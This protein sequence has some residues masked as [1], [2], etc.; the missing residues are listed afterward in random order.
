MCYRDSTW[1]FFK[2]R[3]ACSP[4]TNPKWCISQRYCVLVLLNILYLSGRTCK[5]NSCTL[6]LGANTSCK[7]V[8]IVELQRQGIIFQL[9]SSSADDWCLNSSFSFSSSM[10]WRRWMIFL[11]CL[12]KI[13]CQIKVWQKYTNKIYNYIWCKLLSVISLRSSSTSPGK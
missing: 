11:E 1:V 12:K 7:V 4:N 3:S 13:S 6:D 8:S 9:I 2:G 10:F 5:L